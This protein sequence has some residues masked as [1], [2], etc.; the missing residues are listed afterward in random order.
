MASKSPTV[1][2]KSTKQIEIILN[3]KR[4]KLRTKAM[5]KIHRKRKPKRLKKSRP[6]STF[7]IFPKTIKKRNLKKS[8]LNYLSRK[9]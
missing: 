7:Q 9:I 5:R 3:H 1:K 2:E 6:Y 4:L 8:A